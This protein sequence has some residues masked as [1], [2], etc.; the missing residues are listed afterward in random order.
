MIAVNHGAMNQ[1]APGLAK[2]RTAFS[3]V[4]ANPLGGRTARPAGSSRSLVRMEHDNHA[5]PKD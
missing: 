1:T 3:Y 2:C 4:F 5:E